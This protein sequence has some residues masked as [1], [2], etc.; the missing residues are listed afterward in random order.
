MCTSEDAPASLCCVLSSSENSPVRRREAKA[1]WRGAAGYHIAVNVEEMGVRVGGRSKRTT[2]RQRAARTFEAGA[3]E[4][5]LLRNLLSTLGSAPRDA[6]REIHFRGVHHEA[7]RELYDPTV[8]AACALRA[9]KPAAGR[10]C[11]AYAAIRRRLQLSAAR[12]ER[13][14]AQYR[15]VVPHPNDAVA[16]IVKARRRKDAAPRE[17]RR[18]DVRPSLHGVIVALAAVGPQRM[19]HSNS[20]V[21][22]VRRCVRKRGELDGLSL[23]AHLVV[24]KWSEYGDPFQRV[25][26][27]HNA[28]SV[29]AGGEDQRVSV[30]RQAAAGRE[31]SICASALPL[32]DG[33][34]A[35]T[36][37]TLLRVPVKC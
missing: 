32:R 28:V 4:K 26:I 8:R 7:V 13:R 22:A 2:G 20:L 6:L 17:E 25:A 30:F 21:R 1:R 37:H 3:A 15:V 35:C 5:V 19:G 31:K 10:C 29:L 14:L 24:V 9:T 12:E 27:P 36:P 34:K 33:R 11:C 16:T 23:V 18:R